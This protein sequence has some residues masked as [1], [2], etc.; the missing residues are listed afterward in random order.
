MNPKIDPTLFML[1][2]IILLLGTIPN[3]ISQNNVTLY[4]S[5]SRPF[6]CG[7][8]WEIGYPFWGGDRPQSC[9]H[10]GYQL[11]CKDDN[12]LYLNISS[13][14]YRVLAIDNAT[15]TLRVSRDDL[16]DLCP[17]LLT[18]TTLDFTLFNFSSS[19]NDQNITLYYG[20][21]VHQPPPT[22]PKFPNQFDCH[23]NR[24]NTLSFYRFTSEASVSG[25]NSTSQCRGNIVVPVSQT[26]VRNLESLERPPRARLEEA[27]ADGFSIHWH[28]NNGICGNCT[29]SGGFCGHNPISGTFAC[30][31]RDGPQGLRCDNAPIEYVI[32]GR[33]SSNRG[34]NV[35]LYIGGAILAGIAV[36][37]MILYYTQLRK[38]RQ[39]HLGSQRIQTLSKDIT[40]P[41]PSKAHFT[42]LS[43][44]FSRSALSFT[45]SHSV[46]GR[47][48]TYFGVQ[49]FSYAELEEATDN[50]DPSRVLGDGGFGT[51]YYGVLPS[52]HIVAVK[53]LYNN[54]LKRVEQ[55]MNEVEILTRLRH[56]NLVKLHG[57]TSKR[58]QDLLLVYEYI[59]NGTIADHLHGGR[60]RSGLLSWPVRLNIAIETADALCYLHKSDVIH[61]DVKTNNILLDHDFH[62][63]VADFGISRFFPTDVTHVSTAPQGTPGYVDPEYFQCYQLTE[64]SDV[65]S[66]GV[67]LIELISSLKAVDINRQHHDINLANMAAKKIQNH[68]LNEL[69][70]SSLG[71]ETNSNVRRMVTLV[72]ELALWCLQRERDMRPSMEQVLEG[73]RGIQ[74][75]ELNDHKVEFVDLYSDDDTGPLKGSVDP[76][77]PETALNSSG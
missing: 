27:L 26:A 32:A 3:C 63:K 4:E 41:P 5:C 62:V 65:Y 43:A 30:Y 33:N 21:G 76:P 55:F 45:T 19:A 25:D 38:Q 57:C 58:S 8:I 75:E 23:V 15:Q 74:N 56:K 67:V 35:G 42:H 34:R 51:V 44:D 47:G 10:P 31:C 7:Y 49:V 28:V 9:G 14:S 39:Q 2:I 17:Q 50:F 13:I 29:G 6:N 20:C 16:S 40:T 46:L 70:D 37:L 77:S 48:S 64:K 59:S 72:A 1:I 54:N 22:P 71:F 73:L 60:A 12:T 61:R 24:S 11:N 52:G 68:T 53:R 36:G 69:V 18:N 66:F